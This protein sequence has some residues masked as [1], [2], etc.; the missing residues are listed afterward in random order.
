MDVMPHR[1]KVQFLSIVIAEEFVQGFSHALGVALCL[2][3]VLIL[4]SDSLGS[5]AVRF[6]SGAAVLTARGI[7]EGSNP[8]AAGLFD[9]RGLVDQSRLCG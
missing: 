2:G 6:P 3:C 8:I 1:V 9:E 5:G 4:V 7:A